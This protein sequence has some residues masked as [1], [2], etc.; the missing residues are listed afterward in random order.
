[1]TPESAPPVAAEWIVMLWTFVNSPVGLTVIGAVLAYVLGKVFT[2]KPAW[3]AAVLKYGPI[4]M[5]AVKY[6]EKK[7]PDGSGNVGLRRLDEALKFVIT[8]E[9]KLK[10]VDTESL[11]Q[12]LT[13]VHTQA[14]A[15]GNLE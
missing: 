7:I 11:K 9:P 3:K 14:E 4:L 1:M 6:A 15:S 10:G 13:A 5:Q 12:A 8:L 2:A